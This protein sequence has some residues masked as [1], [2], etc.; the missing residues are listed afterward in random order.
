MAPSIASLAASAPA[1]SAY[2][3]NAIPLLFFVVLRQTT[4]IVTHPE[5]HIFFSHPANPTKAAPEACRRRKSHLSQVLDT[6]RKP[7]A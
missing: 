1:P 2:W 7:R 3:I 6:S 4:Q 5:L